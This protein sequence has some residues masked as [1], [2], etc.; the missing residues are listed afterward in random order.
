MRNKL[1]GFFIAICLLYST[2][3]KLKSQEA[4][5][6]HSMREIP[7]ASMSNASYIPP[8]EAH[9]NFMLPAVHTWA[10]NSAFTFNNI[11]KKKSIGS[12]S[13]DFDQAIGKMKDKNNVITGLRY[14]PLSFGFRFGRNYISIAS[15]A[16]ADFYLQYSSS[17]FVLLNDGVNAFQGNKVDFSEARA[18][19]TVWLEHS[20]GFARNFN[21]MISAGIRIKYINGLSA[22]HLAEHQASL[23]R[24]GSSAGFSLMSNLVLNASYPDQDN[25]RIPGNHGF[26]VDAGIRISPLEELSIVAG[27]NDLGRIRWKANLQNFKSSDDVDFHFTGLNLNEL[28]SDDSAFE[29]G[30]ETVSDSLSG[31]LDF[32]EYEASFTTPLPFNFHT[33]AFYRFTDNDQAGIVMQFRVVESQ[34]KPSAS[35]MYQRNFGNIFSITT[36]LSYHNQRFANLGLGYSLNLGFFQ[37]YMLSGNILSPIIYRRVH[38]AGVQ[39]GFNFLVGRLD[40]NNQPIII[41]VRDDFWD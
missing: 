25:I 35:I 24:P 36:A 37:F 30:I 20:A 7:Q 28:F 31:Y 27:F 34:V 32:N 11:V 19:A 16:R 22:V 17:F 3:G 13:L 1:P 41:E 39:F 33:G 4:L 12:F 29:S 14:E 9:F 26:G 21:E 10:G 2:A 6:L 40:K 18:I 23:N 38:N 15:Q 8:Y 5:L